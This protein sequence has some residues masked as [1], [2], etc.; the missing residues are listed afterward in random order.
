[1]KG[2]FQSETEDT[3]LQVDNIGSSDN[4]SVTDAHVGLVERVGCALFEL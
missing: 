4:S 2:L 1:M 3:Q